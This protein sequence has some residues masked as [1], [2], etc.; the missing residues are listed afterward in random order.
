ME[1][2]YLFTNLRL[3][4]Y[5]SDILTY[6]IKILEKIIEARDITDSLKKLNFLFSEYKKS[7]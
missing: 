7:R 1:N 4:A 6:L 3:P 2:E 5:C